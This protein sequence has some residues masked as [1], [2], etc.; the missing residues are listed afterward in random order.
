MLSHE[1][2][3]AANR[4]RQALLRQMYESNCKQ[5]Q[6]QQEEHIKLIEVVTKLS[7]TQVTKNTSQGGGQHSP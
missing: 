1:N 4:D 6:M 5:K 3:Q 7:Q 2:D